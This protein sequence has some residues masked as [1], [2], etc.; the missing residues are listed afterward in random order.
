MRR[1]SIAIVMTMMLAHGVAF[2]QQEDLEKENQDLRNRV[3]RLEADLAEVKSRM[4]EDAKADADQAKTSVHS[5]YSIQLYGFIKVDAA[6]MTSRAND[7]GN[8][9]RWVESE[10]LNE[11]DDQFNLTARE[12]RFGLYFTGPDLAF[13]KTS[14]RLEVDWYGGGTENK[15]VPMLR[16]VYFQ[17]DWPEGAWT[18]LAGQ[19][20]DL[21]SPLVPYGL[22][23]SVGWWIGNI[24]F[25]RP[26]IRLTKAFDLG[27]DYHFRIQVAASR[28]IGHEWPYASSQDTGK[29]AGFPTV[30]NRYE[31]AFPLFGGQQTVVGLSG[32][33]GEEEYDRDEGGD[34]VNAT[35]WSANLDLLVPILSWL[36][37]KG[38]L[39]TGENLDSYLGGI[40][41]GVVLQTTDGLFV[42]GVNATGVLID[43]WG[44]RSTGG[45][46]SLEARPWYRWIF[47]TGYS[48][49]DPQDGDLPSGARVRN[50]SF[51]GNVTYD[52]TEA[53]R[54]GVEISYWETL[55][56]DTVSGDAIRFQTSL[57]YRF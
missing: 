34:A 56:K 40:G 21:F 49:D 15:S 31:L 41:Q 2:A 33:W 22:N 24:G 16:H 7:A 48:V 25:R 36:S 8:Y 3:E 5:K 30:Q 11:N 54:V 14:A 42:N 29:D 37:F 26:Q 50:S 23:Y 9:A 47:G 18:F 32:H 10:A 35:S 17:L 51:W 38:E 1:V 45:W 4:A 12:S 53:V 20:S 27:S 55:Y 6:Y 52:V 19:T 28:T 43:V 39:W 46:G 13:L 57:I 44:I